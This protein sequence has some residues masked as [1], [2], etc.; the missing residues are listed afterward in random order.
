MVLLEDTG[1][2]V[3][4]VFALVG[5]GLTVLTGDPVWDG[6]GTVAIGVLLGAIALML[7]V[8]M[9]SLLIGEGATKEEDHAIRTVLEQT[10]IGVEAVADRA[11]SAVLPVPHGDREVRSGEDH[12]LAGV[13]DLAGRGQGLVLDVLHRDE[14]DEQRVVV[15]LELR[16]L[17]GVD[18]V[19]DGERV[20]VELGGDAGE[21]LG[22]RLVQAEPDESVLL[23][24][25]PG[26]RAC[27]GGPGRG[28]AARGRRR[29]AGRV[30]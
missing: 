29:R 25:G 12:D 11:E 16:S 18:G 10:R 1:A 23:P 30:R 7:M 26:W 6:I 28:S 27:G 24:G 2:L 15:A 5:V 4:L 21:L 22:G 8:E 3:G 17:M 14:D 19:F 20:Q 9:H 13:D